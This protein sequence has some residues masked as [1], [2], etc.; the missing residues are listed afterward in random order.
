MSE[1]LSWKGF[2]PLSRVTYHVYL[3]HP[4]LMVLVVYSRRTLA[5]LNDFDMVCIY[6]CVLSLSYQSAGL[7]LTCLGIK[8][9]SGKSSA[10]NAYSPGSSVLIDK[11]STLPYFAKQ[12][13]LPY[14]N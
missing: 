13:C 5:H 1:L 12:S 7:H 11:S 9:V 3:I 8:S 6:R 10:L 4:V 2:V 14:M